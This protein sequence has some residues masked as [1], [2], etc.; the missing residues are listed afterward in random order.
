MRRIPASHRSPRW[1]GTDASSFAMKLRSVRVPLEVGKDLVLTLSF[2]GIGNPCS[3]PS[4]AP[5]ARA[6]NRRLTLTKFASHR[7]RAPILMT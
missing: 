6:L 5:E 1:G 3:S 4:A 2:T 7:R